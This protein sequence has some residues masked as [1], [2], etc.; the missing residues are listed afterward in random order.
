MRLSIPFHPSRF[1]SVLALV[2]IVWPAS[3]RAQG[4]VV[5]VGVTPTCPYGLG[6]CWGGA[7]EGLGRL[8]GVASVAQDPDTVNCT[9][10]VRL[11]HNGLPD[12]DRWPEQFKSVV[13][14]AY[15]F[16][17]VEV[18]LEGL[19]ERKDGHLVV[20]AAGA[21]HPVTLAPLRHKLQWNF[22]K[23]SRRQPELDES[24]AYTRLAARKKGAKASPLRVEVTG[25]LTKDA[26]GFVLEVREFLET[27][28]RTNAN[29]NEDRFPI[30]DRTARQ[31]GLTTPNNK[32]R[33]NE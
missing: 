19:V 28:G 12:L 8:E 27:P 25:P 11:K 13:G 4:S 26:T 21:G 6:A 20:T 15:L 2:A 17:G 14:K 24:K 33:R 22:K 10:Q 9:A 23:G 1:S 5:I 3:A 30:S 16:R 7:R 18:T 31:T 29:G 32:E